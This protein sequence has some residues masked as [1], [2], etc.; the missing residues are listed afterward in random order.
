MAD[1]I[2]VDPESLVA[3]S[4]KIGAEATSLSNIASGMQQ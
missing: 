1:E 3:L 4:K 2:Q